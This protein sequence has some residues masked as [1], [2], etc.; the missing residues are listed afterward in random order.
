MTP[1]APL[2]VKGLNC[3]SCGGAL[4]VRG[5]E[6]TLSVV[7]PQCL[8]ILDAKDPNLRVLQT[9]KDKMRVTLQ[10]PLGKR[11]KWHGAEYEAVGRWLPQHR[12]GGRTE[13]DSGSA[14]H[15]RPLRWVKR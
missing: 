10:I 12:E 14:R 15:Q 2:K 1:A 6:H 5:F 8:S 9:F 11:G 7:C 13:T 4:A 3:P